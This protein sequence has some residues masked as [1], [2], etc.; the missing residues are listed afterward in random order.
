MAHIQSSAVSGGAIVNVVE[1]I[2]AGVHR[3]TV[4]DVADN[5]TTVSSAP[6]MLYSVHVNTALS[7]HALPIQDNTTA[8]FSLAASSAVGTNLSWPKG[9]PFLTSL[10]VDPN[11]AATGSITLVWAPL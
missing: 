4:V 1:L 10:V 7:A 6:A 11:D 9:I 2:P 8:V 5:S 3:Y